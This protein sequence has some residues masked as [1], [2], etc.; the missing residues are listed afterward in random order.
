MLYILS[1][2]QQSS[3]AYFTCI[4]NC[5][6]AMP[7]IAGWL[8]RCVFWS[9]IFRFLSPALLLL[10]D[11][12]QLLNGLLHNKVVF[13]ALVMQFTICMTKQATRPD[14]CLAS[15]AYQ[16]YKITSNNMPWICIG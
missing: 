15:Q 6:N 14:D 12:C 3:H 1:P 16:V 7:V 2:W 11:V 5:V 9:C 10:Y 8:P 4:V 13:D